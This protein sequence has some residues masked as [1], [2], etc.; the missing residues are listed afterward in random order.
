MDPKLKYSLGQYYFGILSLFIIGFGFLELL[1]FFT[2]VEFSYGILK[3]PPALVRSIVIISMG[4]F[5]LTGASKLKSIDGLALVTLACIMLWIFAANDLFEVVTTSIL[6][7]EDAEG[8]FNSL[9]GFLST[10]KGPYNPC[11]IL[12]PFTLP[13]FLFIRNYKKELRVFEY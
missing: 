8:W 13:I 12:L 1:F 4:I 5:M 6:P 2:G 11:V 9:E 7:E 10:Y 3:I